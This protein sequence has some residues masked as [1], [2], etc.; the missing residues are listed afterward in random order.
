MAGYGYKQRPNREHLGFFASSL[1]FAGQKPRL[2]ADYNTGIIARV[3]ADRRHTYLWC[4]N[5][6]PFG[7]RVLLTPDT[8]QLVFSQALALRG[9]GAEFK[10]GYL[11][12]EIPA[13]DAV[14]YQLL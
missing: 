5:T 3:W 13:K 8:E 4:L 12:F 14:V 10:N 6:R 2:R 1:P 7:Q 11:S 9:G